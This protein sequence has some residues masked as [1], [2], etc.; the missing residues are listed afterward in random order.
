VPFVFPYHLP[1][2]TRHNFNLP[3]PAGDFVLVQ[4]FCQ[5]DLPVL[6]PARADARHDFRPLGFGKDISHD[7]KI[8][9]LIPPICTNSI[10]DNSRN[11]RLTSERF[12]LDGTSAM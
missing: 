7:D 8:L 3:S 10:R 2:A 5:R 9:T 12:F 6:V 11:S 1:L 4:Q